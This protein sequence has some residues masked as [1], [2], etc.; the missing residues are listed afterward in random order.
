MLEVLTHNAGF[1]DPDAWVDFALAHHFRKVDS[2]R[3]PRCPDCGAAP[4]R[5]LAQYVYFSTL[6]HLLECA[7]CG[8][9][10]SDVRL[11]PDV[12]RQ[13]FESAYKEEFYFAH[14]RAAIFAD[15]ARTIDRLAKPGAH[16][17]DIGGAKGHLMHRAVSLRPDLQ[18]TVSDISQVATTWAA[19]HL[20]LRAIHADVHALHQRGEAYDVIVLSDVIYY[21]PC[22]AELWTAMRD[23]VARH[24]SVIIRVPNKLGYIRLR[25]QLFTLMHS[26]RQRSL[27]NGI[28][29]FNIEHV[30]ICTRRYLASR[31]RGLGFRSIEV[32]PSPLL[33][34]PSGRQVPG[35]L[36]FRTARVASALTGSRLIVTPSMIV[37][38]RD[39][40]EG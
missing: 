28:P 12:V 31:L 18:V 30:L 32:A 40:S 38:G 2:T 22:I 11:A 10:W 25:Q 14:R 3:V 34:T 1:D 21:E 37:I 23:I 15:L 7:R 4:R 6:I 5:T 26:P 20:S 35:R 29:G 19:E 8:L 16:V 36:V 24:G 39:R 27:Q 33:A 9:I 17:L 13:H